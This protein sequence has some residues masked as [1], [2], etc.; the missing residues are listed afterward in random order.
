MT[1]AGF[2]MMQDALRNGPTWFGNYGL[3]G[4]QYGARQL[5]AEVGDYLQEHPEAKLVVSPAWAN[6]T[7]VVARFFFN[8]PL[9]FEMGSISGYIEE[10]RPIHEE[11]VFVLTP[12]EV[13]QVVQSEKFVS[14]EFERTL[15]YPNG[16]D[17]FFFTR[18]RY[19]DNIE[20]IMAE[21]REQR[22]SLASEMVTLPDGEQALARFSIL[23]MGSIQ[24]A[25]DD[26]PATLIRSLEANPLRVILEY[27]QPRPVSEATVRVGG[28]PTLVDVLLYSDGVQ[29][30][31]FTAEVPESP[32]PRDVVLDFNETITVDEIEVRVRSVRDGEPAHVHLWEIS[33]R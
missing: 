29:Q 4:M 19:I 13:E 31:I 28:V 1:W 25:F 9:P 3:S 27:Q 17:G 16:L 7:D 26:N 24:H 8:D 2:S 5:F 10:Y 20:Q 33:F 11:N 6:G 23:D 12:E 30:R 32:T 14:L 22:R 18:L 15:Q 21:E